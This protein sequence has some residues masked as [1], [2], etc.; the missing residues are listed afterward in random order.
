MKRA[1]RAWLTRIAGT[2]T[3]GR[4]GQAFAL[5]ILNSEKRLKAEAREL[6]RQKSM[7][8]AYASGLAKGGGRWPDVA[9]GFRVAMSALTPKRRSRR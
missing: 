8:L 5:D 9:D 2:L 6:K 1:T 4:G 7:G 3:L